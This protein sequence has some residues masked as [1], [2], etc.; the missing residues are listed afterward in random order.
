[1]N[2]KSMNE[3]TPFV[4]L[5]ITCFNAEDTI[6]RS[7]R[8]AQ[9]QDWDNLEI[10][11]VDDGSSDNSCAVVSQMA[12]EDKRIRLVRH[13]KNSGTAVTRSTAMREAKG[14]FLAFLDDDDEATPERVAEQVKAILARESS[15][16]TDLVACYVSRLVVR[17]NEPEVYVEA[18]G[19]KGRAPHGKIVAD[20][21]LCG[22]ASDAYDFGEMGSGTMMARTST[23]RQVGD[24]DPQFRRCAEWDW[25]VRLAFLGGHFIGCPEPLIRQ[26]ITATPD[27]S[28]RK[29][30]DYA[31]LLRR[32]HRAYLLR[33]GE[34]M[35]AI[36]SAYLRFHYARGNR[37]RFRFILATLFLVSPASVL[38][39]LKARSNRKTIE[40]LA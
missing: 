30:L 31:L 12:E 26:H 7:I 40:G 29:P 33:H 38:R 39:L 8:S 35:K 37:L 2:V 6:A 32:K 3:L 34:Y 36:L 1:M 17:P 14:E 20:Y 9:G 18:I 10:L 28:N 11:V 15:H 23:F 16:Q 19:A 21:L 4:T 22:E 24:F 27:K 5:C 13:P 25:A